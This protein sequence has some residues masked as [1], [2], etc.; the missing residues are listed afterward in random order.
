MGL[1]FDKEMDALLR[2]AAQSGDFV[3][4][5]TAAHLDADE[6]SAFA[7]NV[8]PE[9]ARQKYILHLA[10]CEKCRKNLSNLILLNVEAKS[11]IIHA[12]EKPVIFS[13]V[14]W[15][16]K[17]FVVSNLAYALGALVFVFSGIAV[18]TLL[19]N[20]GNMRNSEVS[21]ISEKQT[22]GKGMSSDGEAGVSETY[23]SNSM[24]SNAA[25]MNS[26][27]NSSTN[28]SNSPMSSAPVSMANSN[29]AMRREADKDAEEKS[30]SVTE[31]QPSELAKIQD[32]TNAG[33]PSPP[34]PLKEND[35]QAERQA[36]NQQQN[37]I[38]Q[39]QTQIMPDSRSVQSVPKSASRS[40]S[41]NKK[42][43]EPE[44][45]VRLK[46]NEMTNIGGKTFKRA[47]NVWYDTAYRGQA[48]RNVTR[49]TNE[50]KKLD[51]GLRAIVENLGGTIVVV[52]KKKAY[53]IQ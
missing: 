12:E 31:N 32:S 33:V 27:S 11:E 4:N 16:R 26:S 47:N 48:T 44:D 21:Q 13:P 53:R 3:S 43:E 19:Q 29:V 2:Q 50:Y 7:E 51:S 23:S 28:V 52:W 40:D 20:A 42:L 49:G 9:K 25:S 22:G 36:Q 17:I 1:N 8:L 6:I 30:K 39:N 15:Y 46:S 24:M 38:A 41:R 35:Y 37:S 14:P 34:Q 45:D 18:F 10:D 5:Q